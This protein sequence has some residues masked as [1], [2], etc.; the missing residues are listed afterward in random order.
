MRVGEEIERTAS[1]A[2]N[3]GKSL[4]EGRVLECPDTGTAVWFA[5]R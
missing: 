1:V 2:D 5:V 4:I 3:P